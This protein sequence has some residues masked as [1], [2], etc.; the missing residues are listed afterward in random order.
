MAVGDASRHNSARALIRNAF[1]SV[2]ARNVCLPGMQR[3][4]Q[5]HL[6]EAKILHPVCV[7]RCNRIGD[8]LKK[9]DGQERLREPKKQEY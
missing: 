1:L 9:T 6:A 5:E 3:L 4:C 2:T 8:G 7:S